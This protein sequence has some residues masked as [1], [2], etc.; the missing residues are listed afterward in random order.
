MADNLSK[1]NDENVI[2]QESLTIDVHEGRRV[3][4]DLTDQVTNQL[5]G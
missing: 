4:F 5:Q 3:T 2:C 1:K